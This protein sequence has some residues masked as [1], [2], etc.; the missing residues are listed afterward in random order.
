MPYHYTTSDEDSA[1]WRGFAFRDG[2]VFI[3]TRTKH[4]TTWMQ[5]ICALLI[6]RTPEL[7]APIADLSPW[8]DWT[9][10]PR[11]EVW[12]LLDAQTH[13]RFVKTHTPLDGV[14]LDPRVSYV[15]VARHPLDAAI[16][17]YHQQ[18]NLDRRRWSELTGSPPPDP[19]RLTASLHDSLLA[20]IELDLDPHEHLDSLPGVAA[21]LT[22]AWSRRD[23]ANVVLVHYDELQ[24]D[25]E[26]TM[27]RL[28]GRFGIEID[29]ATWPALVGAAS[30]DAMRSRADDAVP[31][32]SGVI[33]DPRRFFR[34]GSSGGRFDEL[35][36]DEIARFEERI[37]RLTPPDLCRWLNS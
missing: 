5:M 19:S 4:G 3:S 26:G 15:V 35:S 32:R 16:S 6:F 21:H 31:D 29:D 10:R 23:D 7:P 33:R 8:M 9:I 12:A 2:D 14:P 18:H 37:A 34:R 20:W 30:F 22:D 1:R 17:L 25:L 36:A 27:R 13:R 24:R 28:A 11:D